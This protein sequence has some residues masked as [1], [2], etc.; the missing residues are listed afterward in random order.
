MFSERGGSERNIQ[1]DRLLT[2]M[3]DAKD[4]GNR[5]D[6]EDALA[7][8]KRWLRDND[9]RAGNNVIRGAQF[10]LHKA[11]PPTH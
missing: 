3:M 4:S 5:R 11:F 2:R 10:E 9:N 8:A 6:V 7:E 1:R